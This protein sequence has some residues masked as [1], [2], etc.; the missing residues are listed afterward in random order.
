MTSHRFEVTV[1]PPM[2]D[3]LSRHPEKCK[4]FRI[5]PEAATVDLDTFCK[6]ADTESTGDERP[7]DLLKDSSV[8]NRAIVRTVTPARSE[9][10]ELRLRAAGQEDV[11]EN[12]K[13]SIMMAVNSLL[14][15]FLMFFAGYWFCEYNGVTNLRTKV[16]A[17]LTCTLVMLLIEVILFVLY[18]EKVRMKAAKK[19]KEKAAESKKVQGFKQSSEADSKKSESGADGAS[20]ITQSELVKEGQTMRELGDESPGDSEAPKGV[21]GPGEPPQSLRRRVKGGQ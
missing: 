8:V 7:H 10:E 6:M 12:Y 4:T 3:Y 16:F 14:G 2:R 5:C 13:H 1:T 21:V 9:M 20:A 15:L 17:G 19:E 11:Y 18:D